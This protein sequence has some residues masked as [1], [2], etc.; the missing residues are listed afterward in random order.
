M[1]FL[2]LRFFWLL[3]CNLAL[4]RGGH[5]AAGPLKLLVRNFSSAVQFAKIRQRETDGRAAVL[6]L[7]SPFDPCRQR[8]AHSTESEWIETISWLVLVEL[9]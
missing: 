6:L 8:K 1:H 5:L 2:L 7:H 3:L 9:A 4:Q